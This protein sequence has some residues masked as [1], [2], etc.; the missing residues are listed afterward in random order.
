MIEF[1]FPWE[2][3]EFLHHPWRLQLTLLCA[4]CIMAPVSWLRHRSKR[5]KNG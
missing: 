3:S 4:A 2:S 5:S 1:L